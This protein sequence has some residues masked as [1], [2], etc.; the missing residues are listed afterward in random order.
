M[1]KP[2]L[3]TAFGV[4]YASMVV[5]CRA[6]GHAAPKVR[7]RMKS[8]MTFEEALTAKD[9]HTGA[10]KH[11]NYSTW[12]GMRSRCHS[13]SG[14][15]GYKTYAEKGIYVCARWKSDFWA[16][17]ADMGVK[18]SKQHTIERLNNAKG[19]SLK[20]CVWATRQQQDRHRTDNV[21]I[22]YKGETLCLQDWARRLGVS[23][24]TIS[25][26]LSVGWSVA[27]AL[28]T[29]GRKQAEKNPV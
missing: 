22:T 20:N 15:P 23:F 24:G 16:F 14:P 6:F 19:Y 21:F 1:P 10:K 27:R 11:P 9:S 25:Y 4:K 12:N 18:P 29:A 7:Y 26:R 5:A 2:K 3:T 13:T 28:T 8:G 17:V